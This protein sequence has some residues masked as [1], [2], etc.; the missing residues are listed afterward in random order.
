M[1]AVLASNLCDLYGCIGDGLKRL[2]VPQQL[3]FDEWKDA[4]SFQSSLYLSNVSRHCVTFMVTHL[5]LP[6]SFSC[7]Y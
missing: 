4:L 1:T 2:K 3:I 5:P 6:T 7:G